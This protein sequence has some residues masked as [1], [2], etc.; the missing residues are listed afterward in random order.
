MLAFGLAILVLARPRAGARWDPARAA[1]GAGIALI[2]GAAGCLLL[3]VVGAGSLP[4]V[5]RRA[6]RP[7]RRFARAEPRIGQLLTAAPPSARRRVWS[8]S[9]SPGSAAAAAPPPLWRWPVSPVSRSGPHRA[10]G[11]RLRVHLAGAPRDG[12]RSHGRASI[13]LGG[14][15]LLGALTDFGGKSRLEPGALG[16]VVPRFSALA[17]VSVALIA[18]T[19]IYADWV[20]TRDPLGF[21]TP[22][23]INLLV[24]ILVFALALAVGLVNYLDG[25]RELGRRLGLSRRLLVEL[26]LGVAVLAITANLTSGSPTGSDRPVAI[27]PAPSSVVSAEPVSLASCPA[28]RARPLRGGT[29]AGPARARSSSSSSSGSTRTS[30]RRG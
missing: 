28:A 20:Q 13:W 18:L 24:K 14:L 23:E 5:G 11:S 9:G 27:A 25:G 26:V 12:H 16:R 19:G 30:G 10:R 6:P 17:L 21:D 15:V 8:C 29:A 7:P 1:Y 4:A 2:A 22:Y 3:L